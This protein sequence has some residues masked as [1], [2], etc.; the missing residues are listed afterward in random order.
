MAVHPELAAMMTET[1]TLAPPAGRDAYGAV[2]AGAAINPT[3][4]IVY[5]PR[6]T[7]NV[8]GVERTSDI[9]VRLDDDYDVTTSW[10]ITLPDGSSPAILAVE[11]YPDEDG[12]HHQNLLLGNRSGS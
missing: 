5:R 8:E 2:T 10:V 11:S 4:R 3:C 9:Q 7:R 12:E 1:V 6:I